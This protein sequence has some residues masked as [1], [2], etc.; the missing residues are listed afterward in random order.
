MSFCNEVTH[1][2]DA[3]K[4]VDAVFLDFTKALATLP[5]S[6]LLDKLSKCGMSR[7]MVCW[8]K[9]WLDGRAQRVLQVDGATS[10]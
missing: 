2:V 5:H 8:V 10:G 6:I 4:P 7:L 3:E 9:N 1:L